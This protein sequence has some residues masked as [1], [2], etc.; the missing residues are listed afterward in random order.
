MWRALA[1]V[2]A[3]ARRRP[4]APASCSARSGA[5]ALHAAHAHTPISAA[6]FE[7]VVGPLF[8]TDADERCKVRDCR[9]ISAK[10]WRHFQ[11]DGEAVRSSASC[12]RWRAATFWAQYRAMW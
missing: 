4:S 10:I 2:L 7:F 6:E 3:V 9:L 1:V 5:D 11:S 12:A 8:T